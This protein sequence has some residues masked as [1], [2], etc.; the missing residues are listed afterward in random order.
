MPTKAGDTN[1]R[2][3]VTTRKNKKVE[4]K[5]SDVNK[6]AISKFLDSNAGKY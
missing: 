1:T 4:N 2:L 5:M 6:L 3:Y